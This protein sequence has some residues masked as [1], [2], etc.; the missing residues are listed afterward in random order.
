[1][2]HTT[3][4][5]PQN[6]IVVRTL[7]SKQRVPGPPTTQPTT[8]LFFVAARYQGSMEPASYNSERQGSGQGGQWVFGTDK[9]T[10]EDNARIQKVSQ[11]AKLHTGCHCPFVFLGFEPRVLVWSTCHV[12]RVL[13]SCWLSLSLSL[14]HQSLCSTGFLVRFPCFIANG[15]IRRFQSLPSAARDASTAYITFFDTAML[16]VVHGRAHLP[17]ILIRCR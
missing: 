5:G 1:M 11:I 10:E 8:A 16:L 14:S 6:G 17:P 3:N 7:S 9:F 12:P 13:S 15:S 4:P 2:L